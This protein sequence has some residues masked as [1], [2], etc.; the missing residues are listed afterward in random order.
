MLGVD[1]DSSRPI[2]LLTLDGPSVQ[3]APDRSR[4]IVWMI[5]E[6]IKVHPTQDRMPR[7]AWCR[8]GS[9]GRPTPDRARVLDPDQPEGRGRRR[10]TKG[11]PPPTPRTTR[12]PPSPRQRDRRGH[13]RRCRRGSP[14]GSCPRWPSR[15][16]WRRPPPQLAR[17][18]RWRGPAPGGLTTTGV[19]LTVP[20]GKGG[21]PRRFLTG[22]RPGDGKGHREI[23]GLG[24]AGPQSR[25]RCERRAATD[26]ATGL[27]PCSVT[28]RPRRR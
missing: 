16:G 26:G 18:D 2:W 17:P 25:S 3:T 11:P 22:D 6:M 19:T 1:L 12:R 7:Q 23:R 14:H 15:R 28:T 24:Q 5:I 10:P 9:P 27:P 4:P 13:A 20:A 8:P 21:S